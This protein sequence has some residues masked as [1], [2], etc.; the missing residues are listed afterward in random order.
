MILTLF[1]EKEFIASLEQ[2]LNCLNSGGGRSSKD[3]LL[4]P[5]HKPHSPFPCTAHAPVFILMHELFYLIFSPCPG[6]EGVV[7]E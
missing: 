7:R 5:D 3:K 2:L 6:E 1:N 4:R